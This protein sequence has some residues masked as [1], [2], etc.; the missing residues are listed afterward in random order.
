M[1]WTAR[2]LPD[3][4]GITAVVT[5]ASAGIGEVTARELAAHG[6][7]VV[8]ACRNL[9]AGRRA[10]ARMTGEV[11]VEELDLA[12]LASVREFASRAEGPV[13][14]LINNAGVMRPPRYRETQDGHELMFGTNHLGHFALTGLMLPALVA[15]RSPR[16]VTV[17]SI[18]H[19][20]G[21]E[22]VVEA[23]PETGYDPNLYY[24]QSKLANL[25]FARELHGR[26]VE[27]GSPIVSTAAHPGISATHLVASRDGMGANPL[28]RVLA[29]ALM[30]LLYQ[31]ADRGADPTLYAATVAEPG[32]YTGPQRRGESRGPIGP[33]KVSRFARD[34]ALAAE[35][36]RV[37]E[38][39]TGVHFGL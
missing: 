16:V 34:E 26:S 36:W 31:S 38:A 28:V 29:P 12:S 35:L 23:N 19:H 10:R 39:A 37:S 20:G 1:T 14:L 27:S 4:T 25:L 11:L 32:S 6:A 30:P 22:R 9:A 21:D 13:D 5:G 7:R 24:A 2:D 8:L 3:L 15:S 18:A 17:S 33:A